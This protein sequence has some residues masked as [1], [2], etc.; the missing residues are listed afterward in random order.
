MILYMKV[1]YKGSVGIL[2]SRVSGSRVVASG[3]RG[4]RIQGLGF[5]AV[6]AG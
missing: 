3:F 1:M 4:F 2:G 6:G 5:I